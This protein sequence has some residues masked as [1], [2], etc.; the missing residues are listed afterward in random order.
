MEP[1]STLEPIW[2]ATA[3]AR[4]S[5]I[6]TFSVKLFP[7]DSCE[8]YKVKAQ[9]LDVFAEH[10]VNLD[11]GLAGR[12]VEEVS[13]RTTRPYLRAAGVVDRRRRDLPQR[14]GASCGNLAQSCTAVAPNGSKDSRG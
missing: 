13:G 10:L 6:V 5:V 14:D 7:T 2:L 1:R 8:S 3:V 11:R 4:T 12:V 9:H